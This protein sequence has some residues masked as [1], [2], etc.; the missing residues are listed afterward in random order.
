MTDCIG[1]TPEGKSCP[2]PA[3]G[4]SEYCFFHDPEKI[5]Q[6]QAAR[7]RGGL[8]RRVSPT[9]DYPGAVENVTQLMKF[10]NRALEESWALE[11]S[12]KRLRAVAQFLRIAVD[13]V[14]LADLN[15][16]LELLEGLI[17]AS[18]KDVGKQN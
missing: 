4:D 11:G 2:A 6:A 8:A 16:R 3:V 17:Y 15:A 14:G 12:E 13:V 1:V 5:A 10:L 18:N 7:I 9:T